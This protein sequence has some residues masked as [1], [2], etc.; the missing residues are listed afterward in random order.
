MNKVREALRLHFQLGLSVRQSAKASNNSRSATSDYCKRFEQ[1]GVPI[2][3]FLSLDEIKQ[4]EL[5]FIKKY[6]VVIPKVSK[7]MPDMNYIHNELK[8]R[9]K[10]KVTLMLLW[11]EYKE[12]HPDGYQYT[13]FRE[14]YKRYTN[15][16]NPSMRQVHISGEK[17]FVDYSGLT[18]PITNAKTGEITSAQIFVAVLG[19]SGYTFVHAT[20]SQ[21]QQDFIFSHTLAYTFFG[22]CPRVVVPD[23]LKSAIISNNKKGVVV[24][25]SYAAMSRHYNMAVQPARPYKP[26]DKSKAEQG[27]LGIQRWILAKLRDRVFFCVDELNEAIADLLDLYNNKVMK[28]FNKS[29]LEQFEELDKPYL[30]PLPTNRY[31]YKE[32]KIATVNINYHIMLERCEYS[33]PFKF[34]KHK[35]EV[36]YSTSIVEIYHKNILIASHPRLHREG[37]AS[38]LT[39]HMPKNH[40]YQNEKMNPGRLKSWAESTGIN[41]AAFVKKELDSVNHPPNAYKR[42]LAILSLEKIYGKSELEL[43]LGYAIKHNLRYLKSITSVLSKR[44]YLSDPINSTTT[45]KSLF[46]NHENIRGNIYK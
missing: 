25:E 6:P 18:M 11:E 4:E 2:E 42:V 16:L 33:V 37:D 23:N 28:K 17:M 9:K 41:T 12:Q 43:A 36:R 39:E 24:N 22:G 19:A 26:K 15:T 27:V 10:T 7:V 35:V 38:T 14:H 30:Q 34:L 31:I 40:Q 1:I 32:F 13:Q 21:K 45:D 29:R 44:L 20:A 5:L 46:N 8:K 3:E